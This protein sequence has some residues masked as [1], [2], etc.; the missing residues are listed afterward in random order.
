MT[1]WGVLHVVVVKVS[2][3]GAAVKS[4]SPPSARATV[5]RTP[6]VG[7][8]SRTTVYVAVPSSGTVS[9]LSDTRTLT[10]SVTVAA[11]DAA[12]LPSRFTARTWKL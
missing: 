5:I 11:S 2:I 12:P 8:A 10:S 1:V 4:L 3:V 7:A 9:A 6:P